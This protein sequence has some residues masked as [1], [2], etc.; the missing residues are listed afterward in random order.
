MQA[1]AVQLSLTKTS[2]TWSRIEGSVK[3][4]ELLSFT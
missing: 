2:F 1:K 4:K 3:Q